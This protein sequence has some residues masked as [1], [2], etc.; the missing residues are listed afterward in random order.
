VGVLF[1]GV[2]CGENIDHEDFLRRYENMITR[3]F[4]EDFILFASVLQDKPPAPRVSG[5]IQNCPLTKSISRRCPQNH[6]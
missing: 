5:G 2:E 3:I 1:V 4:W 6:G